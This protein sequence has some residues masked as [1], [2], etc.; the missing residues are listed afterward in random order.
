MTL[1]SLLN[2]TATIYNHSGFDSYG[3][4]SFTTS[5]SI[6]CRFQQVTKRRMLPNGA[7]LTID[8]K[9]WVPAT[10]TISID[11]KVTYDGTDYKVI[12]VNKAIKQEGTTHHISIELQKWLP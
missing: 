5:S 1:A 10:Q 9:M 11:D 2:Q 6:S 8:A 12:S 3:R 4:A 7:V